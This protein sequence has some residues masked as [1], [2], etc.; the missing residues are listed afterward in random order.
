MGKLLTPEQLK[1]WTDQLEAGVLE[2]Y[3]SQRYADYLSAMSKFHQYSYGNIILILRQCP[4][5]QQVAGYHTWKKSFDR[6][7]KRYERGITILA[8]SKYKYKYQV[9]VRRPIQM[10]NSFRTPL[11]WKSAGSAQRPYLT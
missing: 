8:P 7:V 4:H 5:A 3:S 10:G 6:Q 2:L 1:V 11:W 9:E